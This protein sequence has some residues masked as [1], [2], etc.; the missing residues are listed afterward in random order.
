M[1]VHPRARG[2]DPGKSRDQPL[3]AQQ[4]RSQATTEHLLEAAEEL[5]GE[6]GADAATL[7]AIAERAG[8]SLGIVYRRFPDKDAVLRAV[9]TR[10]FERTAAA[11]ERS[12]ARAKRRHVPIAQLATALVTG[13]A[14]GYRVHRALLRA[15]VLYARTHPDAE[16]RKRA[17][18]LNAGTYAEVQRMFEAQRGDITH[19]HPEVAVPFAISAVAAMLQERMLFHDVPSQPALSQAELV[20]EAAR[21]FVSYLGVREGRKK[22][23]P[24]HQ[25]P[26]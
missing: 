6:G 8:V 26:E 14:E 18:A 2:A 9:Y 17:A 7:R 25:A 15:L 4:E 13:I 23:R 20:N 3:P 11:N 12:L 16:F 10:F 24:V 21:I 1:A 19:P 5:L 22:S